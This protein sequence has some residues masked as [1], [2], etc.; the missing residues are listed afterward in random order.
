MQ[1]T[2]KSDSKAVGSSTLSYGRNAIRTCPFHGMNE[3]RPVSPWNGVGSGDTEHGCCR[4]PVH[5]LRG[6]LSGFMECKAGI[7]GNESVPGPSRGSR[8]RRA[9]SSIR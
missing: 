3:R 8:Q 1:S 7:A 9:G 4:G 6:G 2:S 5:E